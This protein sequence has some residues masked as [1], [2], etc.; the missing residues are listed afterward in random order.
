[1]ARRI[2]NGAVIE[3][4]KLVAAVAKAL[5]FDSPYPL[6]L[7]GGVACSSQLFRDELLVRLN[8]F[9]TP[10]ATVTLVD[11][12]V[13]GCLK[14]ARAKLLGIDSSQAGAPV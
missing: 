13:V 7:A 6:A 10:P 12:P 9:K 8:S 14:I 2:V 4:V 5:A 1:V 3:A 11:E